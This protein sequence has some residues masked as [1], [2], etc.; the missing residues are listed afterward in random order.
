MTERYRPKVMVEG[1]QLLGVG[2][3]DVLLNRWVTTQPGI[4][5]ISA[6]PSRSEFHA[7][8]LNE[9][10]ARSQQRADGGPNVVNRGAW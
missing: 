8:R 5:Y 2:I 6:N 1:G 3:W 7:A 10:Y 4:R 9:S